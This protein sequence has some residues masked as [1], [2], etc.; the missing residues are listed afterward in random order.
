M[1]GKKNNKGKKTTVKGGKGSKVQTFDDFMMEDN[2]P[3]VTTFADN[4]RVEIDREVYEKI[5]Y[6]IDKAP[7]EIS[8]LGKVEVQDGVFMVTSAILLEQ[9]NTSVTTDIDGQAVAKAMFELKDEPGKLNWWWHSHVNMD[10]FWSGTD[11]ETIH[12]LGKHGW[13]TATVL[14]KRREMKSAY[15]QKGGNT[16]E[17]FIEDIDT[18]IEYFADEDKFKLWDEEY[19]KKVK[20]KTFKSS[21]PSYRGPNYRQ[22]AYEGYWA[23]EEEEGGGYPIPSLDRPGFYD[24]SIF[25]QQNRSD[26]FVRGDDPYDDMFDELDDQYDEEEISQLIAAEIERQEQEENQ[27]R[28]RSKVLK[29]GKNGSKRA[30]NKTS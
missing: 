19:D 1:T 15:Y 6:W 27:G 8:G 16:P 30:S 13:F 2:D 10:V 11:V 21:F 18:T 3:I 17:I 23:D 12:E 25:G 14:N 26:G 22:P 9:E 29:G 7:G 28:N 4:I 5:M 20:D 24:A